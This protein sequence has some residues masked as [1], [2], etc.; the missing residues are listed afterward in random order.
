MDPPSGSLSLSSALDK[1]PFS[2]SRILGKSDSTRFS[3]EYPNS[4]ALLQQHHVEKTKISF[5]IPKSNQLPTATAEKPKPF[6]LDSKAG[7]S[8]NHDS[9]SSMRRSRGKARDDDFGDPSGEEE[10]SYSRRS[11]R[12]ETSRHGRTRHSS[13]QSNRRV[14]HDDH[15]P[16]QE[17]HRGHDGDQHDYRAD[18]IHDQNRSRGHERYHERHSHDKEKNRVRGSNHGHHDSENDY[19]HERLEERDREIGGSRDSSRSKHRLEKYRNQSKSRSRERERFVYKRERRDH[20]PDRS[21]RERSISHDRQDPYIRQDYSTSL[22][23]SSVQGEKLYIGYDKENNRKWEPDEDKDGGLLDTDSARSKIYIALPTK[24]Q[25]TERKTRP[26]SPPMAANRSIEGDRLA[27][28]EKRRISM[29]YLS[30]PYKARSI[31]DQRPNKPPLPA[32]PPPPLPPSLSPK[33]GDQLSSPEAL[34]STSAVSNLYALNPLTSTLSRLASLATPGNQIRVNEKSAPP[35]FHF[36]QLLSGHHTLSD[37]AE[38]IHKKEE[39]V[40]AD[41]VVATNETSSSVRS[42]RIESIPP[43]AWVRPPYISPAC[44]KHRPGIGNFVK[45]KGKDGKEE[46]RM[47]GMKNGVLIE[48]VDPRKDLTMEQR[49]RG[50]GSAKQRSGFYDVSYEWDLNSTTPKPPPPPTAVLITGLSPLTT[51]DQ[52]SKVLRPYGR[53]KEIDSKMDTKSGMQLGICWVKFDGPPHGKIGTAHDVAKLVVKACEGK[54]IGMNDERIKLVL[55]GRGVRTAK[56][57]K[58]EM[59]KRYPPKKPT[60]QA[61]PSRTSSVSSSTK[62]TPI[63]ILA[64]SGNTHTSSVSNQTPHTES[65]STSLLAKTVETKP[66]YQKQ[67]GIWPPA[68]R[69]TN[70]NTKFSYIGDT[71]LRPF[72]PRGLRPL[73]SSIMNY[74]DLP[75]KPIQELEASFTSAPFMKQDDGRTHPDDV[76]GRSPYA[77]NKCRPSR[78]R[79]LSRSSYSSLSSYSSYSSD[80]ESERRGRYIRPPHE[81]SSRKKA[82]V[83]ELSKSE[84]DDVEEQIKTNNYP[85]IY[86]DAKS[87][88]TLRSYEGNLQDHFKAFKPV[89]V[90]RSHSG[91]YVLFNDSVSAYRAQRVLDTTAVQGHRLTLT[92]HTSLGLEPTKSEPEVHPVNGTNEIKKGDWRFLT[93]S[94]KNRQAPTPVKKIEKP[95]TPAKI[96]KVVYS[97]SESSDD[98]EKPALIKTTKRLASLP[99]SVPSLSEDEELRPLLLKSAL[100]SKVNKSNQ[101]EVERELDI[102]KLVPTKKGTKS[103]K[104]KVNKLNE[105]DKFLG[106]EKGAKSETMQPVPN[107]ASYVEVLELS[108]GRKRTVVGKDGKVAKKARFKAPSKAE[109]IE[110]VV[111]EKEIHPTEQPPKNKKPPKTELDKLISSGVLDGEEDAYWFGQALLAKQTGVEPKF[112]GEEA[113]R[114][115]EDHPLFHRSG[116][117]RA[118]GWRKIPQA[119]KSRYLPQRNRAVV[120]AEEAGGV[121]TGRTARL[122]G[123]DQHRQTAAVAANNTIESDLF[124]FNQ[125]RIRKKQLKFARSAI[126]GYGLYAMETIHAGE[127]VCEYVGDLIRA[128]VA[129]VREQRYMKQGIGSSYL[130]RIDNDMVCD[131]TFKGSVSRLINHSCDP[132]AN[133]KIIKVNGQSKIVIYAERTLYPG[134]EILYDY[135]FPLESDPALRVPCL[136]GA[137]T[138]RELKKATL[139]GS[140]DMSAAASA[141]VSPATQQSLM[142][143]ASHLPLRV[144]RPAATAPR[145]MAPKLSQSCVDPTTYPGSISRMGKKLASASVPTTGR[146]ASASRASSSASEPTS[147]SVGSTVS[148]DT[149]SSAGKIFAKPSKEWVLPERAKPGRKVSVDEPDNKRQSQN[150]IS[151][152]AHRARRTDYIQTLE[153]R[154]RQYEANEIH[155]NIRLQEVARALKADNE[156]LKTEAN[157]L[158][159]AYMEH[160]GEKDAW[161]SER[162]SLKK[163]IQEMH[164][165]IEAL[166]AGRRTETV[167]RMDIDQHTI[168]RLVPGPSLARHQDTNDKVLPSSTSHQAELP[169]QDCPIC[170]NP[171]P[172]CPCQRL[173]QHFTL[174]PSA[175]QDGTVA[176]GLCHSTDEC[177]CRVVDEDVKHGLL[178]PSHDLMSGEDGDCGLCT[179]SDFC[180]CREATT[181]AESSSLNTKLVATDLAT[182]DTKS[183]TSAVAVPLR[184]RSRTNNGGLKSSIWE[185]NPTPATKTKEA[186]CTGDPSNCDACRDDS[187]G[188][189]FCQHLFEA[190]D[191]ST[192]VK[193]CV[194]CPG[195]CITKKNH[196]SWPTEAVEAS[197]SSSRPVWTSSTLS[198][199]HPFIGKS[200]GPLVPL[201]TA[202]CNNPELCSDHRGGHCTEDIIRTGSSSGSL[203]APASLPVTT[204]VTGSRQDDDCTMLRPD[205]VWKQLKAHPNAKFASLALLADVVARRTKCLG[206]RVE[207]CPS[208]M[209][210]SPAPFNNTS[211]SVSARGRIP[212]HLPLPSS[213]H[214]SS[215]VDAS[216]SLAASNYMNHRYQKR[217]IEVETSAVRDALRLLDKASPVPVPSPEPQKNSK[218]RK[219]IKE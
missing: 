219:M 185:L 124:A 3:Q 133:A 31:V 136:C 137:A 56:A 140:F 47:D 190:A 61:V 129:D 86:I 57:V 111:D 179:G 40:E 18:R 24:L 107:E 112:L 196:V 123:R 7:P 183:S 55:D 28:F 138:C 188:R 69:L 62:A 104:A 158:R 218:K 128:T 184:R 207:M 97:S 109:V 166:R 118:E 189:E 208:P 53:I 144:T 135:K 8:S 81:K 180:A 77:D 49:E 198:V 182:G 164:S 197:N 10:G 202:Y 78:L 160:D 159:N 92:V 52:V 12:G 58:E 157:T 187:F 103:M 90:L 6:N 26:L 186:I 192:S 177:L 66:L 119:Q 200:D 205:Q 146:P 67:R 100:A 149:S 204:H 215:D 153:E 73:P 156:L 114:W 127:M 110:I 161:E 201:Q 172:D 75:R 209:P 181:T 216:Q 64:S 39:K 29:D 82:A 33:Q 195:N 59:E 152:R 155:S 83:D 211:T 16:R 88:P 17:R 5:A 134:E 89:N 96:R 175:S 212:S 169:L 194:S 9:R 93:I 19:E 105:V 142:S 2:R 126:E 63:P 27:R 206:P 203:N 168:D 76:R 65:S 44:V 173:Q 91:W 108:Q 74:A 30:P 45:T 167:V 213:T 15:R 22:S 25:E 42:S 191:S 113:F 99:S 210:A 46:T 115:D 1:A 21:R 217:S 116:A 151:Q 139:Q 37:E 121:T 145:T 85:H 150:R 38:K 106:T 120:K 125:L 20:D 68:P 98:D 143:S 80:S 171:D 193:P 178:T 87:L 154:L 176:C 117:W 84:N 131:A 35:S 130:F 174:A 71:A 54:K 162:R 13:I 48:V 23:P 95:K 101:A 122:A 79:S 14:R 32:S 34:S 60:T 132:S 170:P 36:R 70:L 147:I 4:N 72:V 11:D 43:A 94:K 163:T 102:K 148:K 141:L 214:A 199:S 50:R 165:E 51:I 41:P